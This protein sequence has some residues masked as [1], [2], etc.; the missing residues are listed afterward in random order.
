MIKLY[1]CSLFFPPLLCSLYLPIAAFCHFLCCY[2]LKILQPVGTPCCTGQYRPVTMD[3]LAKVTQMECDHNY[4]LI[5]SS[6][7]QW[8]RFSCSVPRIH[9]P[10]SSAQQK[11]PFLMGMKVGSVP[12]TIT[13]RWVVCDGSARSTSF[14]VQGEEDMQLPQISAGSLNVQHVRS[15]TGNS[16]K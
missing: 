11:V 8:K 2:F 12:P 6:W 1:G 15:S 9:L 5:F 7:R 4:T 3:I 14:P 10:V 13:H 16:R